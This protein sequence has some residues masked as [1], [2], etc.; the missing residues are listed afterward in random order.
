ML[1]GQK[2]KHHAFGS[3]LINHLQ[4]RHQHYQSVFEVLAMHVSELELRKDTKTVNGKDTHVI[5]NTFHQINFWVFL[6]ILCS[7]ELNVFRF[8]WKKFSI[9]F[10]INAGSN[11]SSLLS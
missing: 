5:Q 7:T 10:Q 1:L 9:D 6:H 8:C 2:F 11:D 4:K 3:W